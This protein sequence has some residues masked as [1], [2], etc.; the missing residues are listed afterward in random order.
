MVHKKK[1]F[2][3]EELLI[4]LGIVEDP[5]KKKPVKQYAKECFRKDLI[6]LDECQAMGG[7]S[8]TTIKRYLYSVV[9]NRQLR[10]VIDDYVNCYSKIYWIK[11]HQCFL[12]EDVP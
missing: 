6:S 3:K 5:K 4:K 8:T 7:L 9:D 12:H 11:S 10:T 1:P 2:K